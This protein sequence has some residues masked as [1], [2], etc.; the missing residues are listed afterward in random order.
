[1]IKLGVFNVNIYN[2]GNCVSLRAG[3][4]FPNI[5]E[6]SCCLAVAL[7]LDSLLV[8]SYIQHETIVIRNR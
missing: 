7:R 5:N 6:D 4:L 1:M 8:L 3:I 2:A